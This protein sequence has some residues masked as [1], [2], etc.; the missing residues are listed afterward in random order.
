MTQIDGAR[1]FYSPDADCFDIPPLPEHTVCRHE[2][3]LREGSGPAVAAPELLETR[4]VGQDVL[5]PSRGLARQSF[6]RDGHR[7]ISGLP[8]RRIKAYAGDDDVVA[9]VC[10]GRLLRHR[11]DIPPQPS[12]QFFRGR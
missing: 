11:T 10:D 5:E 4:D 9:I 2:P 12:R 7:T 8:R 6:P 3:D 1:N